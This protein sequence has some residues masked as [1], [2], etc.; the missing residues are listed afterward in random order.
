[1][2]RKAK[3]RVAIA[4]GGMVLLGSGVALAS[5]GVFD[6]EEARQD[7]LDRAAEN[8]G[9][10][11]DELEEALESATI[12]QIDER[13]EANEITEDQAAALKDAVERGGYPFLGGGFRG[14]GGPGGPGGFGGHPM[15]MDIF[16]TAAEYLG[17]STDE[18]RE[19]TSN[20]QALAE[21]AQG[22]DKSVDG[23]IDALID[24]Q[25]T[26]L[27][28]AVDEGR[29]SDEM[30]ARILDDLEERVDDLVRNGMAGLKPP[31]G[32]FDGFRGGP[33]W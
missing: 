8:L 7:I 31:G 11:P 24:A 18:L 28:E 27:D 21:I 33:G 22:S 26:S 29:I 9:V 14:P 2:E 23:L 15:G 6:P 12:A 4:A 16:D 10:A 3:R 30:M 32:R 5:S 20:G 17:L 19:Q 25:Q 13:L 1:M